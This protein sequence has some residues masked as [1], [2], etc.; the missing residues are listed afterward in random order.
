MKKRHSP[1]IIFFFESA[2]LGRE[3]ASFGE[4]TFGCGPDSG[5]TAE[6]STPKAA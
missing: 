1:V 6:I 3:L 2:G 4:E 5:K